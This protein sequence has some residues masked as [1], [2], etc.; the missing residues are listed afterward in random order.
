MVMRDRHAKLMF[1]EGERELSRSVGQTDE[2]RIRQ[3]I[4]SALAAGWSGAALDALDRAE[5]TVDPAAGSDQRR[6][7]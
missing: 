7:G 2:C 6:S 3:R 1:F 4:E 5:D